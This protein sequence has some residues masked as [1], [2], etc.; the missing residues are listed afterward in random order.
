MSECR[1][2]TWGFDEYDSFSC[3]ICGMYVGADH[4]FATTIQELMDIKAERRCLLNA[5]NESQNPNYTKVER[6]DIL[7]K[8]F[9]PEPQEGKS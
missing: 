6:Y 8:V 5:W 7:E 9:M 2:H 1:Y 4:P 3:A